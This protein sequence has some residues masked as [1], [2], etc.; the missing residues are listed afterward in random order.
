MSRQ[1][2]HK[3]RLGGRSIT[4]RAGAFH[5]LA[6]MAWRKILPASLKPSQVRSALTAVIKKTLEYRTTFVFRKG[7]KRDCQGGEQE[8]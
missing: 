5:H 6:D 7:K 8:T 3:I 4:Y 2:T 1:S